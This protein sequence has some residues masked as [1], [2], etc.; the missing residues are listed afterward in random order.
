MAVEHARTLIER[1]KQNL[2]SAEKILNDEKS[3]EDAGYLLAQATEKLLKGL[4]Q[5]KSL[6]YPT[7]EKGHDLNRLFEI[8]EESGFAKISSHEDVIDLAL[9]DSSSRYDFIAVDDRLD[10]EKYIKKVQSLKDLVINEFNG[11][12]KKK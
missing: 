3:H 6:I 7:T 9:Y 4:C 8:L 5:T 10:L 2:H 12:L 11:A 1:A